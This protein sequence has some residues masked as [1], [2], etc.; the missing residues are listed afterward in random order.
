MD[1]GSGQRLINGECS[2]GYGDND[3]RLDLRIIVDAPGD[4]CDACILKAMHEP[5]E[6]VFDKGTG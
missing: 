2:K 6:M 1:I 5:D 3:L 4:W